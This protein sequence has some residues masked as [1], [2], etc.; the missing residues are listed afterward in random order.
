MNAAKTIGLEENLVHNLIGGLQK[1]L[2]KWQML[3]AN[4]FLSDEMK[5]E[6]EGLVMSRLYRLQ[7]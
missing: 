4:S 7:N 3:I 5:K 1:A 6:Y 2:P